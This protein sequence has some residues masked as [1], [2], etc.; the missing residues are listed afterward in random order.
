[1]NIY[2]VTEPEL[3]TTENNVASSAKKLINLINEVMHGVRGTLTPKDLAEVRLTEGEWEEKIEKGEISLEM[4][5]GFKVEIKE[6][7]GGPKEKDPTGSANRKR[8]RG[9]CNGWGL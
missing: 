9:S 4:P 5:S 2:T 8:K 7:I 1:M 6:A 3:G